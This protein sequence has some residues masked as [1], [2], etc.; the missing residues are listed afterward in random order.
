MQLKYLKEGPF[1]LD[2]FV[3]V[4]QNVIDDQPK[5]DNLHGPCFSFVLRVLQSTKGSEISY[6]HCIMK[7]MQDFYESTLATLSFTSNT[8]SG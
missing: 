2:K 7:L 5:W 3:Q 6:F 4:S 1:L 8:H